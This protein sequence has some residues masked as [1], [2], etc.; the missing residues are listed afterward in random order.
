MADKT[1]ALGMGTLAGFRD[2]V[3]VD[4]DAQLL[5]IVTDCRRRP[6]CAKPRTLTLKVE[7]KPNEAD[8]DDVNVALV[9]SSKIPAAKHL[10]RVARM[11]RSHQLLLEFEEPLEEPGD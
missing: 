6:G 8:G 1:F 7:C 10:P 4:F 2:D 9:V 3:R 11:T 5:A